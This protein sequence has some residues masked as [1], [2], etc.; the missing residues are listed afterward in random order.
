MGNNHAQFRWHN[1]EQQEQ[2][3]KWP[4]L[5]KQLATKPFLTKLQNVKYK[6]KADEHRQLEQTRTES[7]HWNGQ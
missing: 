6:Q 3:A 5:S 4:A 1:I 7:S 2:K